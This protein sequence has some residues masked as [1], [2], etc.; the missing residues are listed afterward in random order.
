MNLYKHLEHLADHVTVVMYILSCKLRNVCLLIK[1][2]AGCVEFGIIVGR[3]L[4]KRSPPYRSAAEM[5][6]DLWALFHN[7]SSNST[8]K[9][10]LC[11]AFDYYYDLKYFGVIAQQFTNCNLYYCKY[12]I[13]LCL[14][15]SYH[16]TFSLFLKLKSYKKNWNIT[17]KS[18]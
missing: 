3:L 13:A 5:V 9:K 8:V 7:L 18:K 11:E 15:S 16:Q 2:P 14:I 4:G 1:Q 17:Q 6:S 10:M 12:F